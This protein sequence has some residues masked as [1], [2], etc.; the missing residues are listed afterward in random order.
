MAFFFVSIANMVAAPG[1]AVDLPSITNLPASTFSPILPTIMN[2]KTYFAYIKDMEPGALRE[3]EAKRGSRA[4]MYVPIDDLADNL[5]GFITVA[6]LSEE[7]IPNDAERTAMISAL[8]SDAIRISGYF[9]LSSLK[10]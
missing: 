6:W 10:D 7:D 9:N 2:H 3:L 8:E 1:I 5:I 4:V